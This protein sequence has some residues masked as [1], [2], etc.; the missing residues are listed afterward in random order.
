[1]IAGYEGQLAR[2]NRLLDHFIAKGDQ[3]GVD[4]WLPKRNRIQERL[5]EVLGEADDEEQM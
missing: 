1:M 4:F 5:D 3:A 2:A